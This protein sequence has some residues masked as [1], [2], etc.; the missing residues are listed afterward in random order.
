MPFGP[1]NVTLKPVGFCGDRRDLGLQQDVLVALCDPLHQR[2]D[3]ILVGAGNDLVHQFD[4]RHLDPERVIDRR[5]LEADDPATKHKQ[6]IGQ[7]V[8]FKRAG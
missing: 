4:N 2:R 5:H 1:S 6:P 8:E 3:D 7:T